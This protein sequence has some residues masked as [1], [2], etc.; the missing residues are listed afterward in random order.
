MKYN[1]HP[2]YRSQTK[3]TTNERLAEADHIRI[4]ASLG[5]ERHLVSRNSLADGFRKIKSGV[6]F[7]DVNG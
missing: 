2:N 3:M 1:A 5:L 7:C 4:P 6:Q